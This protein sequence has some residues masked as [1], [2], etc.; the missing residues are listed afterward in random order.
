V[1]LKTFL[2][3]AFSSSLFSFFSLCTAYTVSNINMLRLAVSSVAKRTVVYTGATSCVLYAAHD[4]TRITK[5]ESPS[6][7][8]SDSSIRIKP[9]IDAGERALR[10]FKTVSIIV[11][12]YQMEHYKTELIYP[13]LQKL[14]FDIHD[15]Q[16]ELRDLERKMN[17]TIHNLKNAQ[18]RYATKSKMTDE[19]KEECR[20]AVLEAAQQVAKAEH[21][22]NSYSHSEKSVH[23]QAAVLLRDLCRKNK[24]CYIKIGQ[25]IANLDHLVPKQYIQVLSSLFADAPEMEYNDVREVIREEFGK[26]PEEIFDTFETKPIASASLAQVHV[27]VCDGRKVAVKVQHRGLRETSQ[28]DLW[29][30]QKVIEKIDA[31]FDDFKYNWIVEE[32]APN[33]PLELDFQNEGRNADRARSFL[34]RTKL[35]CVVPRIHWNKTTSR[36]LVMDFEEG[37]STVDVKKMEEMRVNKQ[38]LARLISSVFQ[39]QI[40]QTGFVHCD[41]HPANVMWRQNQNGKLQLVLLDHGLY[42]QLDDDF[43]LE[44]AYLWKSLMMADIKGIEKSCAALGVHEMYPLLAAMLTSRPFDE[45]QKRSKTRTFSAVSDIDANSDKAMIRGYAQQYLNEIIL[46]LDKVPRQMLLLFKLNDCI[47]HIDTALGSSANS[48]VI[49]GKYASELVYNHAKER[50]SFFEGIREW[51]KYAILTTKIKVYEISSSIVYNKLVI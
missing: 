46:M 43:R 30:L 42:K 33:L 17:D 50:F 36:V 37:W 45:I 8:T 24:G 28:G 14:G 49:S 6:L 23:H 34:E 26:Y 40:F 35:N 47:R 31:M 44:Y 16:E 20:Q 39:S 41:P 15:E 27:A 51:I 38:S 13:S 19:E 29:V 11:Y 5:L 10:L 48:L 18:A 12:L 9:M 21:N 4:S 7:L 2:V 22:L 3:F 32:I 1:A 25:H